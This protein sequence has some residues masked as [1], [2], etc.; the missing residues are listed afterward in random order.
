M[1]TEFKTGLNAYLAERAQVGGIATLTELI[2]FNR[3]HAET[4]MPWFLQE[5]AER[6]EATEGLD[7]E[8]YLEAL[9]FCR[10]QSRD[11]GIDDLTQTHGLEAIIAP[12]T[13]TP[14]LIDWIN[15]DNR[16]GGS[17][18]PAA[19]AGYPNVTVPMGYV[20]GLPVGLSLFSTAWKEGV[21]LSIAAGFETVRR[22]RVSPDLQV[23]K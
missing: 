5:L 13:C 7:S 9:E 6:A 23:Q 15:G 1:A 19:I 4:V 16:S 14:W 11:K 3:D 21:L 17:A 12:T 20:H 8:A 10:S 22:C 18:A 2:D